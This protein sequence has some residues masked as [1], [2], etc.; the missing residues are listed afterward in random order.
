MT[1]KTILA[2]LR[3]DEMD[4]RVMAVAGGFAQRFHAHLVALFVEPDPTEVLSSVMFD[5]GGGT[6]FTEQLVD[7]LQKENDVRRNAAKTHYSEWRVAAGVPETVA[8]GETPN[9]SAQLILKVGNDQIVRDQA[10]AADLVV[11]ALA[12]AGQDEGNVSLEVALLDAGRPVVALPHRFAMAA[13]D[14]PIAI[15]WK[16]GAEAAHALSAALPFMQDASRVLVLHAGQA[17]N[18]SS[19]DGVVSYLAWH[20]IRAEAEQLGSTGDP[21]LLIA[22]RVSAVGASM[23]V[24]GAYTHSRAREFVFGGVTRHML[25]DARVPLL[26]AH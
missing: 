16:P 25:R 10:L 8:P 26:L 7:S 4:P 20:G 15:A 3:G 6:Y 18:A 22:N 21:E 5:V 14:A 12:E 19:L 13:E 2:S 11:T 17:D 24:M 9:D 23:L 1:I